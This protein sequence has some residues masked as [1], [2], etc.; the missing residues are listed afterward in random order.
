MAVDREQVTTVGMQGYTYPADCTG[1]TGAY[2]TW[3]DD[4]VVESCTWTERDVKGAANA[5]G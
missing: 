3:R 5:A 4:S 2:D 1:L